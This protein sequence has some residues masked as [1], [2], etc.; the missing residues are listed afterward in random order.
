MTRVERLSHWFR[1]ADWPVH[2]VLMTCCASCLNFLEI[3]RQML[4]VV[5][6]GVCYFGPPVPF[7]PR[8]LVLGG[9]LIASLAM[10]GRTVWCRIIS[11]TGLTVSFG[12]YIYWWLDSYR[13]FRNLENLQIPFLNDGEIK[14]FAYLYQ[15]TPL[16]LA[17]ALSL[18]IN[19]VI[20]LDRLLQPPR[21]HLESGTDQSR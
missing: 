21:L 4:A 9:L 12:T 10:L 11:A 7:Y 19:L 2:L 20:V 18:M 16:D 15:G 1:D 6:P 3:F 5:A 17:V 14:Q 13:A 8:L